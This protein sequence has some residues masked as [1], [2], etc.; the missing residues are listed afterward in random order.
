MKSIAFYES[1]G[2]TIIRKRHFP[3]HKF[4]LYFLGSL[5]A[6][7]V[8]AGG[9]PKDDEGR[10]IF[11]NARFEP[12]LELT[13]NHGTENEEEFSYYNGNESDRQGFGHVG[14]LVDDVFEAC[15]EIGKLGHGFKKMPNDGNMKGLAFAKDPDGYLVEVIKRGGYDE[16]GTMPYYFEEEKV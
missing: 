11:L 6:E 12:V 8:A 7:E 4:S 3:E 5:S 9:V 14:F 1:L 10:A 13:H 2:M 16:A 15:D